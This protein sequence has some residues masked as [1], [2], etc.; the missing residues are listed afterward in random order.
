MLKQPDFF[1]SQPSTLSIDVH[2]KLYL[3]TTSGLRVTISSVA[4][5]RSSIFYAYFIT[6]IGNPNLD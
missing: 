1:H 4:I 2:A 5:S 3:S 6:R